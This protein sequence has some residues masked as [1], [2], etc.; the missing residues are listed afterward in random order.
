[1]IILKSKPPEVNVTH[2]QTI[3][4]YA[5]PPT[6]LDTTKEKIKSITKTK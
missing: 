1:M 3:S 2:T 6:L 5:A 4:F